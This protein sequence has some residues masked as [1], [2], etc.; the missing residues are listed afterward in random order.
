MVFELGVSTINQGSPVTVTVPLYVK[1]LAPVTEVAAYCADP[2]EVFEILLV[3]SCRHIMSAMIP[4]DAAG[5]NG[6][7]TLLPAHRSPLPRWE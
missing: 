4:L 7:F 2:M 1:D 3:L 6:G 5:V